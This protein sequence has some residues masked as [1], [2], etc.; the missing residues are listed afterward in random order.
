MRAVRHLLVALMPVLL[1]AMASSTA[2][3]A[4]A[5]TLGQ[6]IPLPEVG[7]R[8][9]HMAL[10]EAGNRL[11][12]AEHDNGSLDV[13]DL[14][15][16]AAAGRITDLSEPQG[17]AY[18]AESDKIVVTNGGDGSVRFFDGH[19]LAPSG[20]VNLGSDADNIRSG[21][22][23][24]QLIVGYGGGPPNSSAGL[25]YVD[26]NSLKIIHRTLLAGH[27]EGFQIDKQA[28]RILVNVPSARRMSVVDMR[29]GT[30]S[31]VSINGLG[32][33][34]PMALNPSDGSAIV[35]FRSPSKIAL[36]DPVKGVVASANSC[37]DADD[38][39]VDAPRNRLYVACGQGL[40]D[41]F[42]LT[43]NALVPA[44]NVTTSRGARTAL[45][46]AK[47]DRLFVAAP[48]RGGQAAKILVFRPAS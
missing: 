29:S 16:G 21:P 36:I 15:T 48:A 4:D 6:T 30:V 14:R 23:P 2:C 32:A 8:I 46:D 10:D 35:A 19:S 41:I 25:T 18:F 44:G 28:D 27:P 7:G 3:A 43:D 42:G 31:H 17:V 38:L 5:L 13:V 45:F 20:T 37:G 22:S 1:A 33:N 39:F 40:V 11:F 34:F 9:D 12:V 26:V 24:G 47:L